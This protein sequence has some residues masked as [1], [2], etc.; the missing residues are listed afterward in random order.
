PR[1]NANKRSVLAKVAEKDAL[2]SRVLAS[3]LGILTFVINKSASVTL[4]CSI[5]TQYLYNPI[6][7][8]KWIKSKH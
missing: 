3:A 1:S 2:V 5:N 4:F 7:L 8:P 6:K